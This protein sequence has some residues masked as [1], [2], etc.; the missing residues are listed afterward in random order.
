MRTDVKIYRGT[1]Y[2]DMLVP[3]AFYDKYKTDD[4]RR[5]YVRKLTKEY[6]DKLKEETI[7][8]VFMKSLR[9]SLESFYNQEP[10]FVFVPKKNYNSSN[11]DYI[12]DKENHIVR[13]FGFEVLG[14]LETEYPNNLFISY[15]NE[16]LFFKIVSVE[17]I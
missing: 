13:L 5:E 1:G 6:L 11:M 10:I 9:V 15:E 3:K 16:Q 4:G 8:D 17:I 7:Q 2:L 12:E 14:L